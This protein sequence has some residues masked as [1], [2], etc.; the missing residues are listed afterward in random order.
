MR[1]R[2]LPILWQTLLLIL[3][4]LVVAQLVT[5]ALF[6]LGPPPRGDFVSLRDVADAI[7]PQ[8]DDHDHGPAR[9][10]STGLSPTPPGVPDAMTADPVFT[11][12]LAEYVKLPLPRLRLF[13]EADQNATFPFQRERNA[14]GVPMR[15]GEPLFFNTVAAAVQRHDGRWLMLRS[16]PKPWFSNWQKNMLLFFAISLLIMLPIAFLFARAL[17]RPI[18]RFALSVERLGH[19]ADGVQ[20]PVEGPAE[21]RL[22]AS[23]LNAMQQRLHDYLAERTAMIGA[24]AHDLRTPLARIAFRIEGA[25]PALR[26]PVQADVEQMR[27]MI[28]ATIGYLKTG[29]GVVERV[30]VDLTALSARLA[31]HAREMG[32]EVSVDLPSGRCIVSG[33]AVALERLVQNLLDNA[34]QYAGAAEIGL[35]CSGGRVLLRVLDRGPGIPQDRVERLFRPFERGEPSRSRT[36]GG[37]GLGLAIGRA[38]ATAHGG[39]LI[40]RNR[41]GGGLEMECVLPSV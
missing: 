34:L 16:T 9:M 39:T 13:Y 11:A 28:A 26:D 3:A 6:M 35:V 2:A 14:R 10:T 33:D 24:I 25:A 7:A 38:I 37:L 41:E 1:P 29:T 27:A 23:A 36:T 4:S 8:P 40:A 20:V 15:R 21:L 12:K 18:R 31:E 30:R 19:D 17:A 22:T 5:I 32:G